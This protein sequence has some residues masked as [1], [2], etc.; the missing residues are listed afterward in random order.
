MA[1][2]LFGTKPLSEPMLIYYLL[3]LCVSITIK[4]QS[5]CDKFH[6]E[7]VCE[8]VACK[9]GSRFVSVSMCLEQKSIGKYLCLHI[10]LCHRIPQTNNLWH[11][12]CSNIV[13]C[14]IQIQHTSTGDS[15]W[16]NVQLANLPW[17]NAFSSMKMTIF[18]FEFHWFF[19]QESGWQ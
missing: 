12:Y 11:C 18:R 14:S 9:I 15:G 3:Y 10:L 1:C 4:L 16:R 13:G 17:T 5:K 2:C 7:N 8:N 19:S 6:S